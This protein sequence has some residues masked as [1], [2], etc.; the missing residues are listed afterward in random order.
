MEEQGGGDGWAVLAA[1]D[2]DEGQAPWA[3]TRGGL[4]WAMRH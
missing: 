1:G 3:E 2:T 4:S